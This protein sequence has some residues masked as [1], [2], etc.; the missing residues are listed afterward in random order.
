MD[1]KRKLLTGH[2]VEDMSEE[3]QAKVGND[4]E[5]LP[6][7]FVKIMP[8]GWIYP[9]RAPFFLD[10]I[11]SFQH[12]V[13]PVL[14]RMACFTEHISQYVIEDSFSIVLVDM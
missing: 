4:M 1:K 10:K 2:E 12:F 9:G 6:G 8:G 5:P 11:Q 14:F 3:W 13:S 7:G